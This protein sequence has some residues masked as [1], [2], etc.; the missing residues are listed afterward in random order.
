L[1]VV[2]RLLAVAVLLASIA[3][4]GSL[5]AERSSA[6]PAGQWVGTYTLAGPGQ[7]SLVVVGGHA[8]VAL[9]VGHADVQTVPAK[10]AGGR[11]RFQLPGRPA[12]VAFDAR[13][14]GGRLVGTVRQGTAHGAFRAHRGT[15]PE[16]VARGL[17][18]AGGREQVVVDDPYGPPRL[19]DPQSGEVHALY[20]AGTAFQIGAGFATR[21]PVVGTARF[22]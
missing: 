1:I 21:D 10:V 3:C 16:L 13:L 19:L 6:G 2:R 17:Y 22:D 11:V 8:V 12:P 20:P 7:I 14:T 4:A 18:E 15:A 9:G 5:A